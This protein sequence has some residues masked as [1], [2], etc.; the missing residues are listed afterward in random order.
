MTDPRLGII[1]TRGL[2]D[3][4]IA[5]PIA[6]YYRDQGREILWPILEQF[7]ASMQAMAPWVQW[8][9]VPY[10][11]PGRYFYDLPSQRLRNL[12]VQDQLCLYQALTNHRFHEERYFQYTSFDQYKYIRAQVPFVNKWRLAEY[13]QR[14]PA[15]ELELFERIR[16]H[17]PYVVTHL[18]GSDHRASYDPAIIP[19]DYQVIEIQEQ[20]GQVIT[21]WLTVISQAEAVIMTDSV[22]ANLVDQLNIGPEERY[23]IQRSHIGLTPVLGQHWHWL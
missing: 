1:Q 15:R 6:G 22:Y 18:Q 3:L 19:A 20:P 23:F 8:I 12:G 10:D 11:A 14:D 2:G 17:G 13:I 4:V 5:L 16:P 9:P 21:D 7:Q